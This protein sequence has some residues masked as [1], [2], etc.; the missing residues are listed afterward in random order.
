M[1]SPQTIDSRIG[2]RIRA[3]RA[4]KDLTLEALA[5]KADVSRA[6]LSRIER[7]ESSPTAHLLNKVCGGLGVTLSTLF[8]AAEAPANP[9]PRPAT[10]PTGPPPT[11]SLAA[12][13]N[14]SGAPPLPTTCAARFPRPAPDPPSTSP[15]SSFRPVR[16]S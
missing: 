1:S 14:P 10:Q 2:A 3:L 12:P 8:A 5:Q 15:R 7:G 4:G 9:G 6:M 11:R 16:P 13:P